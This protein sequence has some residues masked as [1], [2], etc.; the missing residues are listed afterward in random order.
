M[1]PKKHTK[2]ILLILSL[3]MMITLFACN[4]GKPEETDGEGV[5]GFETSEIESTL[6]DSSE[7]ESTSPDTIKPEDSTA[8]DSIAEDSTAEDTY[9]S[10]ET[11]SLPETNE[12]ETSEPETTSYESSDS[13]T[14]EI[15]ECSHQYSGDCVAECSKCGQ[16]RLEVGQHKYPEKGCGAIKCEVCGKAKYQNHE[17]SFSDSSTASLLSAGTL[18]SKCSRCDHTTSSETDKPVDP[19]ILGMPI[20]YIT[21]IEGERV[22]LPELEK[23]DGEIVVKYKYVSN[24]LDT[25]SFECYS[26]IKVQGGTSAERYDK[27]NFNIKLY[28]DETLLNKN[29]VD[30]GWGKEHKYC[31]KA[32]YIDF[33]Q[34]RNIVGAQMFAQMVASRENINEGLKKAPNYGLIDGYPILVYLNGEFYGLYTMNIPKD[35]WT[36]AMEG[37]ATAKEALLMADD[38]T[39]YVSLKEQLPE[40]TGIEAWE[41]YGFEVEYASDELNADWIRVSFNQLIGLLNSGNRNGIRKFLPDRLDIEAAIDNMIFSYFL[42][43]KD[44]RSK[45]ILWATYDGKQWIPSMYDMD[46]T[47][48]NYWNGQPIGTFRPDYPE[49]A[50]HTFPYFDANGKIRETGNKMWEVLLTCFPEEVKARYTELRKSILTVENT[51][52]LFGEFFEKIDEM[53]YISDMQKWGGTDQYNWSNI[54]RYNMYKETEDQLLRLDDFFYS[55][56]E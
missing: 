29:K 14:T 49:D 21:E 4:D 3:I 42:N 41:D 54:T 40:F 44:N 6:P 25:D 45:N 38:W 1:N 24:S 13:E 55:L 18:V 7:T 11:T 19:A 10:E 23:I 22:T 17:M 9:T 32:N 5:D 33:S 15:I 43:A 8:E 50:S 34:A 20:V 30:L 27:K 53:A 39:S 28:T 37:D 47:F 2:L 36:F 56:G 35:D 51:R 31:M 26:K 48:G 12:P 16:T 52:A 46:G